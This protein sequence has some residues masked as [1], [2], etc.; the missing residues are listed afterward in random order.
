M[1]L[2]EEILDEEQAIRMAD[3]DWIILKEQLISCPC[4]G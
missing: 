2:T 1:R 4:K 3:F